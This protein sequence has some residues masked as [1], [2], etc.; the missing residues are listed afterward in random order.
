[1][2]GAILTL[3]HLA[4]TLTGG[5]ELLEVKVADYFHNKRPDSTTLYNKLTVVEI[6][7]FCI[8]RVGQWPWPRETQAKLIDAVSERGAKV[9]GLDFLYIEPSPKAKDDE[10]LEKSI[11]KAGNVFLAAEIKSARDIGEYVGDFRSPFLV[12]K[13]LSRFER[14]AKGLG[15]VN[16]DFVHDNV[17]GIVRRLPL[18]KKDDKGKYLPSLSLALASAYQDTTPIYLDNGGIRFPSQAYTIPT[19]TSRFKPKVD[20]PRVE[21]TRFERSAYINY[22]K[23]MQEGNVTQILASDLLVGSEPVDRHHF[24]GRVVLI[25][26]NHSGLDLKLTP[27][28]QIPGVYVQANLVRNIL[29]RSF[30]RRITPLWLALMV[31]LTGALSILIVLSF[32]V[33]PAVLVTLIFASFFTLL[34]YGLFVHRLYLLDVVPVVTLALTIVVLLELI[35]ATLSLRRRMRNLQNLYELGRIF[36]AVLNLSELAELVLKT[37]VEMTGATGAILMTQVEGGDAMEIEQEGTLPDWLVVSL[38]RKKNQREIIDDLGNNPRIV[39]IEQLKTIEYERF[40]KEQVVFSPLVYH[41]G[42]TGWVCLSGDNLSGSLLDNEEKDYWL[43]LSSIVRTALENARL[44]KLATVDGLTS[45]YVRHFFD[46]AMEREFRRAL[47]Y[48]APMAMLITDV[49]K[50]KNFND[51]Y[52]HQMGD[53]VLRMVAAECKN[54]VR[55]VD[56]PA[57]YGGEEFAIIL[58][59]TNIE[60]AKLTAERIRSHIEALRIEHHGE[61][62]T[63]TISIGIASSEISRA[64]TMKQ[65]I[66]EA[67]KALYRAKED[68]RNRVRLYDAYIDDGIKEEAPQKSEDQE[69]TDEKDSAVAEEAPPYGKERR[70]SRKS[71]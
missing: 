61:I 48:S 16:V 38:G 27:Y 2:S 28:G 7:D 33:V 71:K 10:A 49:D 22:D 34:S 36:N 43:A 12:Q 44:Y 46:I 20:D 65:F 24:E 42:A 32:S 4:F 69:E 6:S 70:S 23:L 29:E 30:F 54:C 58:P 9:I 17:D 3:L 13:P 14:A 63:I 55:N 56:I 59:D 52:G 45:L 62:I 19:F 35:Q 1:M 26:V 18:A 57:R 31:L 64:R 15:L 47:R 60:G 8:E 68:G 50:F 40:G 5:L 21:K 51:T 11:E 39:P 53:R 41:D 25:G 37:Y 67:D 66:E